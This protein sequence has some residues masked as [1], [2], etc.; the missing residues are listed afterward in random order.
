MTEPLFQPEHYGGS[1]PHISDRDTVYDSL[2]LFSDHLNWNIE[3]EIE[4]E[5]RVVLC[6]IYGHAPYLGLT[7][8]PR[9]FCYWCWAQVPEEEVAAHEAKLRA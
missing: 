5:L 6:K 9:G 1:F 2:G 4:K 7:W 8:K 3:H